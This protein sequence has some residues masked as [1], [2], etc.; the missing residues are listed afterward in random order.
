MTLELISDDW[1]SH[2]VRLLEC[3]AC[4]ASIDRGVGSSAAE[5]IHRAHTP[6]DFGLEPLG[7]VSR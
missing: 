4:G 1:G 2:Y 5:H 7:E 3:P 6:A